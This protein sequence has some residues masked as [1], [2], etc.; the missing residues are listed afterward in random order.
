MLHCLRYLGGTS[1]LGLIFDRRKPHLLTAYTDSDYARCQGTRKS[2]S[3]GILTFAGGPIHWFSKRQKN[4]TLSATQS[5]YNALTAGTADVMWVRELLAFYGL[6]PERPTPVLCDNSGAV[7]LSKDPIVDQRT[8]HVGVSL[9]FVRQQQN[10]FFTIIVHHES[11]AGQLADF[12]TKPLARAPLQRNIALAG[13][14]LRPQPSDKG[15]CCNKAKCAFVFPLRFSGG[16]I[17]AGGRNALQSLLPAEGYP[18]RGRI[19]SS[20]A[21]DSRPGEGFLWLDW[22][23]APKSSQV[24]E[25]CPNNTGSNPDHTASGGKGAAG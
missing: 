6:P 15:A 10:E 19:L 13:M 20:Q 9:H 22:V 7:Y 25:M 14:T 2:V 18:I 11:A 21:V 16:I 8:R 23:R 24:P 4:I 3:G 1:D 17:P 5:E 12:L